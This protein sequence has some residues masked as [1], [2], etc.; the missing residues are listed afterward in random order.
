MQ[1]FER[2]QRNRKVRDAAKAAGIDLHPDVVAVYE[3]VE[4]V[5]NYAVTTVTADDI[6]SVS[7]KELPEM[8]SKVAMWAAWEAGSARRGNLLESLDLRAEEVFRAHV[9]YLYDEAAKRLQGVADDVQRLSTSAPHEL[10]ID[11]SSWQRF[12]PQETNAFRDLAELLKSNVWPY[13][14]LMVAIEQEYL[15]P[16]R[17][18]DRWELA[19]VAHLHGY[20][21][22]T[23]IRDAPTLARVRPDG[24]KL[25]SAEQVT[26]LAQ[27]CDVFFAPATVSERDDRIARVRAMAL[28]WMQ[29]ENGEW[30]PA[31]VVLKARAEADR[32]NGHAV[33]DAPY[34]GPVAPNW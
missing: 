22:L 26:Y 13:V 30:F 27:K 8:L 3:R 21:D 31:E 10:T 6:L 32:L 19:N 17:N 1:G 18:A 25:T 7:E 2:L 5:R 33:I 23:E 34:R 28:E 24:M 14:R 9:D 20:Y 15:R 11:P 29:D 16:D 4:L 12:T